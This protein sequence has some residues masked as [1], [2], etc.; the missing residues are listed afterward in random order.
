MKVSLVKKILSL[1]SAHAF[2]RFRL[3]TQGES[4]T[5]DV[6]FLDYFDVCEFSLNGSIRQKNTFSVA[7]EFYFCS[8]QYLLYCI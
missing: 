7:V 1:K 2:L 8:E 5:R 6:R 3:H 4:I